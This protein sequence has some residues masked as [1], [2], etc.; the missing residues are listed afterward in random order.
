M[1]GGLFTPLRPTFICI[2]IPFLACYPCFFQLT[3]HLLSIL[4]GITERAKKSP[5]V[6]L[7]T[8]PHKRDNLLALK[9]KGNALLYELGNIPTR[10]RCVLLGVIF[11]F[12]VRTTTYD[13][14]NFVLPPYF[15]FE[16]LYCHP[17]LLCANH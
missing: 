8:I 12:G 6:R 7:L 3:S 16:F 9:Q 4:V 11:D 2:R 15:V 10:L 5:S 13:D 1:G 14:P 17:Y